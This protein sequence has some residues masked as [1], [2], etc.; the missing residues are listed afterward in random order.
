MANYLHSAIPE[1]DLKGARVLLRADLNVP[2][3][4]GQIVNDYRLQQLLPTLSLIRQKGGRIIV[5]THLGRPTG[6]D[7]AYSTRHLAGWFEQQGYPLLFAHNPEEAN[8]LSKTTEAQLILMENLRFFPGE[9]GGDQHFAQQLAQLGD[10][11]VND[12]FG[13]LHRNDTSI[14]LV[15]HFFPRNRRSIGLLVEHELAML[16]KLVIEP[17]HPYVLIIGGAK[18]KDKIPLLTKLLTHVDQIML[19]PAIVFS[20]M[21][22]RGNAVGKSLIDQESATA[23]HAFIHKATQLQKEILFPLDYLVAKK[24]IN[25]QL[26][27]VSADAIP[28]DCVGLSIGPKT[29]ASWT[30]HINH[31]NTI[32]FNGFPGIEDRPETLVGTQALLNA[33]ANTKAFTVVGGGDTVSIVQQLKFEKR[34][35]F[36]STGGGATIAYLSGEPLPGLI[37]LEES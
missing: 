17:A 35:R 12:A 34:I 31:A 33:M 6:Q 28:A 3:D 10:Y 36:C 23:C 29:I 30:Q 16:C 20:F 24:S 5:I 1:W 8:A 27:I 9:Q 7:Q 32:F 19:C 14:V 18:I 25:G 15:P 4:H 11:F 37:A 21:H 13:T 26:S 22:A 2:L